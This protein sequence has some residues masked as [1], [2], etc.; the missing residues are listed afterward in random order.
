MNNAFCVQCNEVSL[1][2]NSVSAVV[3]DVGP[4]LDDIYLCPTCGTVST[5]T[6]KGWQLFTDFASI[7]DEERSD[8]EFAIRNIKAH[9]K[10]IN[11]QKQIES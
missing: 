4:E 10:Q 5:L 9:H 11:V 2:P 6:M 3:S 8:L 7:T 1:T